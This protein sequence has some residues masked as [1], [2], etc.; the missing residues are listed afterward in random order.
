MEM[1]CN[2]Q[3]IFQHYYLYTIF[4]IYEYVYQ[5]IY[6]PMAY[7]HV[8]YILLNHLAAVSVTRKSFNEVSSA[9]RLFCNDHFPPQTPYLL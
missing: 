2:P 1:S 8:T 3:T 4:I 9:G 7:T 6:N 5:G